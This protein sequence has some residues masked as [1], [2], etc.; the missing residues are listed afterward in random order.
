MILL[1]GQP[2][3]VTIF[4]DKT[5]QVWKLPQS[6]FESRKHSVEWRFENEAE[7]F[8]LAQL[9]HLLQRTVQGLE[10]TLTMKYLPYARQDKVI[11]NEATFALHTFT[12]IINSLD[13]HKIILTDPHNFDACRFNCKIEA[14]YPV[15]YLEEIAQEIESFGVGN[16]V[17]LCYPDK[18]AL[19]KYTK[20]YETLYRPYI[21]GEKVRDQLTG[22]ITSYT[23]Y[24]ECYGKNVIIVDD[25]CDG[26]MTFKLLAKDL[27]AAGA[28]SVV[29]FVTHGIFSKGVRTLIDSG[30][31]RV[32]T[33]DGEVFAQTKLV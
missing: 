32:F 27:L 16:G 9:Q 28:C 2:I 25:I 10:T 14:Q 18:G 24:G 6:T 23:L 4:P 22:N 12:K 29:L 26:G 21:F 7:L 33:A 31:T 15:K 1:N 13:F 5:S 19:N 30:I 20:V 11:G 8:H 17:I 3:P